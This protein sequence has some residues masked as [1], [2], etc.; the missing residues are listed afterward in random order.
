MA[1]TSL[2]AAVSEVVRTDPTSPK[3]V[4]RVVASRFT[5]ALSEKLLDLIQ[6]PVVQELVRKQLQQELAKRTALSARRSRKGRRSVAALAR[7]VEAGRSFRQEALASSTMLTSD[8]AARHLNMSREALNQRRKAGK[9]LGL[10]GA[11][12]GVRYPS[13]QFEDVVLRPLPRILHTLRHL[14]PWGHYLFFTNPEPLLGP[15]ATP[16]DALRE[17]KES[18]VLRVAGLLAAEATER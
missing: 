15:K 8:E 13:W 12:R 1:D 2:E 10:E 9:V 5:R 16:L 4:R 11:K 14:D 6:G 7:A 3:T 18:E 17:G